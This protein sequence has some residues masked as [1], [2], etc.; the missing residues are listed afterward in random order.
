MTVR[1]Y[2][3]IRDRLR[4][5]L[6]DM[7]TNREE[8]R[9][10]V[11][12]P[13]GCGFALAAYMQLP[14]EIAGGGVANLPKQAARALGVEERTIV[15]DAVAG[16]ETFD[17]PKLC[18]MHDM[19]F[20]DASENLFNEEPAGGDPG[21]LVLTTEG[22]RL[23]ASALFYPDIT[24]RIGEIVGGDYY[25]LPSSIHEVL[26]LPDS[27][28]LAPDELLRMV[29]E[30]NETEVAPEERLG[31]KVLHYRADIRKLQVAAELVA[32]RDRGKERA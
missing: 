32:E 15:R 7:N 19:L 9:G 17:A 10:M 4:I 14:E 23:G 29:R 6:V 5:R 31:T 20:G 18:T 16:S 1:S 25:V 26:I 21:F 12:E 3:D 22:G 13:V 11:C 27:G 2:E 24:G 8:L 30:V 28:D